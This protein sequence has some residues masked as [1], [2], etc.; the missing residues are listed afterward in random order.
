MTDLSPSEDSDREVSDIYPTTKPGE[1][2]RQQSISLQKLEEDD[3]TLKELYN[4]SYKLPPIN[5]EQRR[6]YRRKKIPQL[7]I[8]I[9]QGKDL[10]TSDPS[11]SA[12]PVRFL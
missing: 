9:L 2:N 4:Y 1:L 6:K 10:V 11:G 7:F 5:P 3:S 8:T 12:D